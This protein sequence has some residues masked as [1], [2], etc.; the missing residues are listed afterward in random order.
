PSLSHR[1][2]RSLAP[3]RETEEQEIHQ[4]ILASVDRVNLGTARVGLEAETRGALLA[5]GRRGVCVV[6]RRVAWEGAG[7]SGAVRTRV[8]ARPA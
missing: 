6:A 1:D 2:P 5:G 4:L 7:L 3:R 8:G